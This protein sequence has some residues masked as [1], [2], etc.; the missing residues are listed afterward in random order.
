QSVPALAADYLAAATAGKYTR[1]EGLGAAAAIFS[2]NKGGA[3]EARE[4]SSGT[5]DQLYLALRLAT[6]AALF[7]GCPPPL[8]LH[9]VLVRAAP[10]RRAA[11]L[12]LLARFA[13]QAQVLLFTCQDYSEYAGIPALHLDPAAVLESSN[14]GMH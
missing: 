2:E 14:R 12:A 8:L 6:L 10:Q 4:L 11:L 9:D 1:L 13:R 7:P 5:A 3:L